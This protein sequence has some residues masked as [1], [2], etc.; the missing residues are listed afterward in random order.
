LKAIYQDLLELVM[1]S[2]WVEYLDIKTYLEVGV[3]SG[4]LMH[5]FTEVLGLDAFGIDVV[6]P[7][8][9][10]GELVYLGDSHAPETVEWA[11]ENAPYGMVL[12]DADHAH[13]AV[14]KDWELYSGM[15][16][17]M[18]VLHDIGHSLLPGPRQVWDQVQGRKLEIITPGQSLGIGILFLDEGVVPVWG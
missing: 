5:Y 13:S 18:V 15:A 2:Y 16:S 17:K 1:L 3:A 8:M 9:V 10:D 4:G 12:I 7:L 6:G 14:E 11:E